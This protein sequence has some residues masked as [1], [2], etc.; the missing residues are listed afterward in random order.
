MVKCKMEYDVIVVGIGTGGSVAAASAAQK[1]L[2]VLAIDRDPPDELAIKVCGDATSRGYFEY[3][4]KYMKL[5]PPRDEEI[6]QI[7]K[8]AL[9]YSPD[10]EVVFKMDVED[11]QSYV[12]DRFKFLARLVNEARDAGA[13]LLTE[14]RVLGPI[15]ENDKVVGVRARPVRGGEIKEYRAKIVMDA[16]GFKGVI[17]S[18]LDPEKTHM[19]KELLPKDVSNAYREIR[20]NLNEPFENPEY[21]RLY[22]D[23]KICPGGYLWEFPR[24]ERSV[25]AGL[26]VM[27]VPG[28]PN[29]RAQFA[30]YLEWRKSMYEGSRI[31][32][33]GG[34]RV[35]LRRP[36]DALVWNGLM[37]IGD[38]GAMVKPTDGGGIG[39]AT[40][41]GALAGYYAAKALENGDYST[42]GLWPYAVHY[43]REKG[44]ITAPLAIMKDFVITLD[45][46]VI[47]QVMHKRILDEK[48]FIMTNTYAK[49]N[50]SV[51]EKARRIIRAGRLV[52][53]LRRLKNVVDRMERARELYLNYPEDPAD[54]LPWKKKVERLYDDPKKI[55]VPTVVS[56]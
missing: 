52:G 27:A 2:K 54:F 13:E 16:S 38:A 23:Q 22:F 36:M 42:R 11:G 1:G 47:N 40:T 30:K 50:M 46:D 4:Q 53:F 39:L 43:M 6:E 3:I 14:T 29:T 56:K 5:D 8:G 45:D 9:L 19:D 20:D 25:N 12:L 33:R 7:I 28:H 41:A 24:G 34:W 49:V 44:S 18:K 15:V 21:I 48:D 17:R 26:G 32:H 31:I 51:F 37:L 55:V 35:P 10:K